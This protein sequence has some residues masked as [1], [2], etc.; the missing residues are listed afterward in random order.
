MG[1]VSKRKEDLYILKTERPGLVIVTSY[2]IFTR[3]PLQDVSL[4]LDG[5]MWDVSTY[6]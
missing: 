5:V 3:S 4:F 2:H 6:Q 1:Y